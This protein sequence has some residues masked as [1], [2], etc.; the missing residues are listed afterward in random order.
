VLAQVLPAPKLEVTFYTALETA[1]KIYG[2][3]D[4]NRPDLLR[5]LA[6][7]RKLDNATPFPFLRMRKSPA[8]ISLLRASVD[9]TLD[10]H[11]AAWRR[12]TAGLFEYQI[13]ATMVNVYAERGC[14]RNACPPIV[15]SGRNSTILHY[16]ETTAAWIRAN[17]CSRTSAPNAA[18][19][20]PISPAPSPSTASSAPGSAKFMRSSSPPNAPPS[21]P[22]GPA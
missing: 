7:E 16:A 11:R 21:P 13:G 22:S 2:L 8:E 10:A 5:R 17:F 15:G 18:C 14:E 9:V 4:F 1:P 20:P 19:T 12:A 6:G 3:I